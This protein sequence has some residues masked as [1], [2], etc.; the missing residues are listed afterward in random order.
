IRLTAIEVATSVALEAS[1]SSQRSFGPQLWW[2]ATSLLATLQRRLIHLRRHTLR[3]FF[4][5]IAA[6]EAFGAVLVEPSHNPMKLDH[7]TPSI[8]GLALFFG[9]GFGHLSPRAV[10]RGA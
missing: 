4:G 2:A 5:L 9:F 10:S 7:G 6:V 8:S 3:L 1:R